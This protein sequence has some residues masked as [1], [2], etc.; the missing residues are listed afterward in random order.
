MTAG[1]GHNNGPSLDGGVAWRR[2][3]W[4]KARADLI[5]KLPIEILRRR[6]AR[7]KELGLPY[8]TY[9]SVRASTGRDVVGFLFSNNALRVHRRG[10]APPQAVRG[11][12]DHLAGVRRVALVPDGFA[13]AM[14]AA[15]L[16]AILTAP[17]AFASWG[18]TRE[19]VLRGIRETGGPPDGVLIIG[20]TMAERDWSEAARAAGFLTGTHFF[21]AEIQG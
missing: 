9:A 14:Q 11:K 15:P 21:E 7:A 2:H 19:M 1:V 18:E 16:D 20:E 4:T 12:L 6:V 10:E 13:A 5:P 3:V 17:P 8:K